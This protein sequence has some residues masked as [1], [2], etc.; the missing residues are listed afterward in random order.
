MNKPVFKVIDQY[1]TIE[2]VDAGAKRY[3]KF[4]NDHEQ[5]LQ[6]KAQPHIPQH[7]YSR[8]IMLSL[9]MVNPKTACVL[10]LG[11]GTLVKSLLH[12]RPQLTLHAVEL[13]P[14]VIKVAHNYFQLQRDTR[15]TVENADAF[16]FIHSTEQK[17]D[18]VIADLYLH[19]GIDQRQ[20]H[21][22]FIRDTHRRLTEKGWLVLNYW[23]DHDLSEDLKQTLFELF[24]VVY[25]C[26]SG[27]GNSIFY[28]GLAYPEED[29]FE[30]QSVK[31]LANTLGFSLNY[32]LKR[33]AV[34]APY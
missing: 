26:N 13:R 8:A 16:E 17:F 34:F 6:V 23:L 4:G 24:E 9:L 2:V 30:K 7:E 27:G 33:M 31:L 25:I 20:L 1:G 12:A 5:S 28:C 15:L 18:L 3:L 22:T 14:A 11:A 32:Y 10:G 19:D 21:Q 29:I